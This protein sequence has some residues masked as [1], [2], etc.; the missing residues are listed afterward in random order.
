MIEY[1]NLNLL[2]APFFDKY[3]EALGQVLESGW[4]ILGNKLKTFEQEYA[5]YCNSLYCAGV[6]NGLEALTISLKALDYE[7]ESEIIVPSNTYIATILSVLNNG[8]KPVLVEPDLNTYNINPDK[9]EEQ[10]THR[11]K[12]IIVVHLYGKVCQMDKIMA[13]A[14]RYNLNVIED[15]AQ[16]HGAAFKKQIAGSFGD[17]GA[18]SFYPTKNLGA[19]GDGGAITT[20]KLSLHTKISYLR[21]YGSIVKYHND[22]IGYNSRLDE[23][24]AAFL[25][26]K[27]KS[28]NKINEH[29]RFLANIYNQNLKSDFIKPVIEKE[30]DDV[31]HIYCIRHPHRDKLRDFLLKNNI[32]TEVHYPIPPHKQKALAGLFHGNY[33]I[34][35]EIHNTTL[36]LPI[37]YYHTEKDIA[38]VVKILNRF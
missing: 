28:L 19:L 16:A 3:K 9:I 33:P 26:I 2:N 18:H 38:Y 35:E 34:A 6:A 21:N 31:Y 30:Y 25:S 14:N 11:T 29:K 23:L 17:F 8:H 10:I 1:E 15:C 13:I 5:A 32:K 36:S 22:V 12:A 37:S 20:N 7:A 4:F 27:L 24:Q